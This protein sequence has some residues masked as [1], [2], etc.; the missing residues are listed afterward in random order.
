MGAPQAI[1]FFLIL[2]QTCKT[3][4]QHEEWNSATATYTKET[5]GSII[6]GTFLQITL[7]NVVFHVR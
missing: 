2:L 5:N 4:A 6:I 7:F 3:A 1:V